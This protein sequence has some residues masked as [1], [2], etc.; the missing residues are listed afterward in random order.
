MALS[1]GDSLKRKSWDSSKP[2]RCTTRSSDEEEE[3]SE[4]ED[5]DAKVM[6]ASYHFPLL[7]T[8]STSSPVIYV[9]SSESIN[10]EIDSCKK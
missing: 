2:L 5:W 9:Y 10:H 3:S 8:Q 4:E 7:E 6:M 1:R